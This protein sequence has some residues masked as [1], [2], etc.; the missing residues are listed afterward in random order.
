M[1]RFFF[2]SSSFVLNNG[3]DFYFESLYVLESSFTLP[4]CLETT[5][6]SLRFV[7]IKLSEKAGRQEGSGKSTS[8]WYYYYI[9]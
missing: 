2:I 1:A 8:L 5:G 7:L 9:N 4:G 3:F 6:V